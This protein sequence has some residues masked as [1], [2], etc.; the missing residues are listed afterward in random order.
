MGTFVKKIRK[1]VPRVGNAIAVNSNAEMLI[2]LSEIFRTVFIYAAEPPETKRKNI[3]Y[4]E[5]IIDLNRLP[6]ITFIH[7]PEDEVK[8]LALF[9]RVIEKHQAVVMISSPEGI[10]KKYAKLLTDIRYSVDSWSKHFQ[11]WKLK[12]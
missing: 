9:Q 8:C 10:N 7:I 3:I 12:K 1:I 5:E 4:R 11:I 2:S 6:E